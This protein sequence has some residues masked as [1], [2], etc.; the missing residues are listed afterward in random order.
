MSKKR[1]PVRIRFKYNVD[2][3]EI[4]E[5]IID[6]NAVS[7]S[8]EYH[9]K[10]ARSVAARLGRNPDITDAG[11][12]RLPKTGPRQIQV[13]PDKEKPLEKAAE[14][15]WWT[16]TDRIGIYDEFYQNTQKPNKKTPNK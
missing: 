13:L 9:D 1:P 7:S 8:E 11:P 4:E 5:F 10:V 15:D 16:E 3:G 6:D 2:T 14:K 12:V